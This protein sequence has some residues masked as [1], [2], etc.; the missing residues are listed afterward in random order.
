MESISIPFIVGLSKCKVNTN[1]ILFLFQHLHRKICAMGN[2]KFLQEVD[3]VI[4]RVYTM[5]KLQRYTNR[6]IQNELILASIAL[7]PTP[8]SAPRRGTPMG[9][10]RSSQGAQKRQCLQVTPAA[11]QSHS[12]NPRRNSPPVP[13]PE[14]AAAGTGAPFSTL[15]PSSQTLR[16]QWAGMWGSMVHS[17]LAKL[18]YSS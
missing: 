16:Y 5:I 11:Q 3:K 15:Q 4:N 10:G 13:H 2:L 12:S 7:L 9:G 17:C 6:T 8:V 1:Y 14:A 18:M